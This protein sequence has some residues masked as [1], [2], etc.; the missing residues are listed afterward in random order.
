MTNETC[1]QHS[2]LAADIA[3]LKT[4]VKYIRESI[5]RLP[6]MSTTLARHDERILAMEDG[7][8]RRRVAI[9]GC[10]ITD[11]QGWWSAKVALVSCIA[12]AVFTFI[13]AA[14]EHYIWKAHP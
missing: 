9:D 13:K 8:D 10:R 12:T 7:E 3:E 5:D 2:K 14:V 4:D 11:R 6:D 1:P